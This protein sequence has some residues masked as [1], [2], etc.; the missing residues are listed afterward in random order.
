MRE[1]QADRDGD[2]HIDTWR[3]FAAGRLAREARDT[4]RR[5]GADVLTHFDAAGH[6]VGQELATAGQPRQKLF[7]ADGGQVTAQCADGDGD[8]RF[9]SRAEL[10]AGEIRRVLLDTDGD[11]VADRREHYRGGTR[12][13]VEADTN[14]DGRPDV[15]QRLSAGAV[16]E[17]DEDTDYDGELD[18]RFVGDRPSALT[19]P[20]PPPLDRLGCGR[21]DPFW[22]RR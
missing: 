8:G 2:C 21:F 11:G 14:R 3:F 20:A 13:A 16:V 4:D 15:V 5:G 17:Q 10:A 22:K 19:S 12:H 18:R 6:A 7:L 9:E 1:E